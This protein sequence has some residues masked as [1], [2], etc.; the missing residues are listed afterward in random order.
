MFENIAIIK[1]DVEGSELGV[2]KGLLPLIERQRP[3]IIIEILPCH[4]PANQDRLRN[5]SE[6]QSIMAGYGYRFYRILKSEGKFVGLEEVDEIG[7]HSDIDL[8]DYIL[9]QDWPISTAPSP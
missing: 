3:L 9:G 7:V 4:S 5:Q 6:L 1:I 8:C 2:I